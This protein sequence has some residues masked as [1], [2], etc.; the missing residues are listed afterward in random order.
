MIYPTIEKL[1]KGEYNRYQLAIATAKCARLITEEYVRQRAAAE[2]VLAGNKDGGSIAALIDQDLAD[3]KAVKNAI[4]RLDAGKFVIVEAASEK[5]GVTVWM[6]A[7][8]SM[9]EK[10]FSYVQKEP[11][12]A[13]PM[14]IQFPPANNG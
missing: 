13:N 11:H 1:T 2:T 9:E 10:A 4:D 6:L 3:R 8:A 5:M 12:I 7:T 14:F